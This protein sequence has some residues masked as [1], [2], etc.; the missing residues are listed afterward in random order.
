MQYHGQWLNQSP[1]LVAQVGRQGEQIVRG[2]V[3]E[4]TKEAR[5][6]GLAQESKIDTDIVMACHA[7]LTVIAV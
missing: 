7:K 5:L 1:F 6:I 4:L 2:Q 3:N